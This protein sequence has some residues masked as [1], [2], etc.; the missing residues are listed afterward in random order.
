ME[1]T[2]TADFLP[3][4]WD[5]PDAIRK[6]V[7]RKPGRQRIIDEEGH[8]LVI[9]HA[10]PKPDDNE[11][12]EAFLLWCN[13]SDEWKSAP[14]SG[15]LSALDTHLDS[16][17]KSIDRLDETIEA[18]SSS[19]DYFEVTKV[20][21][22]LL[23]ATRHLLTVM[24]TLR[25]SK[26]DNRWL[27][28]GRDRAV[29]LERG[30]DIATGDAKAGLDFAIAMNAEAQAEAAHKST[31]E[32]RRLNRLAAFFFPLA[33]LVSI[34]GMNAPSKVVKLPMFWMIL[35]VG[36]GAGLLTGAMVL[37]KKPK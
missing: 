13:P 27:I 34:F 37:G 2:I 33:T 4:N 7:G 15:G 31:N 12:R 6:R 22:P 10:V 26:P 30:I 18:A 25:K 19:R 23:R 24:E 16:Y 29:D 11:N 14:E 9:L 3:K 1:R 32:A 17:Q 28:V 8:L 36:V 35:A 21:H 20:A 5:L